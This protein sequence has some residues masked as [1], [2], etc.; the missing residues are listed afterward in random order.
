VLFDGAFAE[1]AF[2]VRAALPE[3]EQVPTRSSSGKSADGAFGS[4]SASAKN[5]ST[6]DSSPPTAPV[7]FLSTVQSPQPSLV[8]NEAA[9]VM[10]ILAIFQREGRLVD[11]LEQDVAGFQD[12]EVGAA[13]RVVHAGCRRAL[14]SHIGLQVVREEEEGA[15]IVVPVG[16]LPAEYKLTGNVQGSGPYRGTLAHRGWKATMVFLPT[17]MAGHDPRVIAPAEIEL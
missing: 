9:A 2:R 10:Q 7:P 14:R 3:P 11:F 1:R 15:R 17:T 12:A 13:A 4:S 5:V 6:G 8:S 16:F